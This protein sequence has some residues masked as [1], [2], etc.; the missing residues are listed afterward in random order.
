MTKAKG[1]PDVSEVLKLVRR[2]EADYEYNDDI[3]SED[4]PEVAVLKYILTRRLN[5]AERRILIAYAEIGSLREL[6][7]GLEVSRGS[8]HKEIVRIRK[9]IMN[10]YEH[11]CKCSNDRRR[12]GVCD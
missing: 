3:F 2:M 11:L 5:I 10:E 8:T 1:N 7:K 12:G 6:S 9:K 4:E